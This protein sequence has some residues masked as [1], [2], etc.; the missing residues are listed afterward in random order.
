MVD[1]VGGRDPDREFVAGPVDLVRDGTLSAV[2]LKSI[3]LRIPSDV[4]MIGIV[5]SAMK[6][7]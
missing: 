1:V 4:A 5:N 3:C 7:E 6:T 2:S